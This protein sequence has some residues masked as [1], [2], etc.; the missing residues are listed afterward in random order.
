[1]SAA[2]LPGARGPLALG[3]AAVLLLVAGLGLWSV[4]ANIAGAV[5]AP[6]AVKV[7]NERQIVQHPDGGVV[8]EILA[9]EGDT[10]AA[11][12]VVLRLDGTFLELEL[13]I[14]ERQ[15]FE[16]AVRRSRLI[17]ERDGRP[18]LDLADLPAYDSLDPDWMQSQIDGQVGLFE[19][20]ATAQAQE[21]DQIKEQERQIENQI[22]GTMAQIAAL[23]TQLE[24]V[25]R[26][27]ENKEQLFAQNLIQIGKVLELQREQAA[28]KGDIGR[29]TSQVAES[30]ARISEL[31]VQALRL[32][33]QRR[34]DAITLLRDL[35]Y[36][37]IELE[38]RR[39]GL[40]EQLSRLDVRS[41]SDGVVFGSSVFALRAVVQ[42]AEPIMYIVPKGAP[43]LVAARIDPVHVDEV[44]P[45][46]EVSL[47]L[48]S[49]DSRTTPEL[50]GE[51][52]RISPD[53]LQDEATRQTYFE[54]IIQPDSAAL[55]D[56]PG[57][58]LVPGMPVEAF[59]RTRDR[60]PLS[61]LLRPLAVYFDRAF[62]EE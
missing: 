50:A 62:R 56:L 27:L 36:G 3:F 32:T 4:T 25:A 60:T 40:I 55:A 31:A 8:G 16:T 21:L 19:V 5:V 18:D 51:V 42:P 37:E 30:R 54:A 35:Q 24:L 26:D 20:R 57:V 12:D 23:E 43:L 58:S 53:A 9:K 52:I 14:I 47:R 41:P 45:G 6:G 61:Y 39:L 2:R 48:T 38:E 49:Y 29:L 11:G 15:L 17:A 10:V 22:E 34:E 59:L 28:L 7:E 33:N 1:M 46:Q 44:F 13:A